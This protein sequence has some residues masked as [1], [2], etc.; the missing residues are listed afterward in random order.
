[1]LPCPAA[2]AVLLVCIQLKAFALGVAMVAVYVGF[3]LLGHLEFGAWGRRLTLGEGLFILLLAPA[4]FEP[5]RE[6]SA[7][8]HDRLIAIAR[9]QGL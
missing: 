6:L 5:L 4:F 9:P 2:V 7:V 3:H 8:W 1:M